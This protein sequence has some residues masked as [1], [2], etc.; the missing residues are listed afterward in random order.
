MIIAFYSDEPNKN[1]HKT[2]CASFLV[3]VYNGLIGYMPSIAIQ[4]TASL[5]TALQGHRMLIAGAK[6]HYKINQLIQ[7]LEL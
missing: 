5:V 2:T 6:T 3:A 7:E 1:Q 4:G